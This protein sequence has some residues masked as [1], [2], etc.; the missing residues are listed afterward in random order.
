MN[1]FLINSKNVKN[2]KI[3]LT[4]SD[5][6]FKH[7]FKVHRL[8]L[9]EKTFF[10]D[11]NAKQYEAKLL[12]Y[13]TNI[14]IFEILKIKTNNS[15]NKTKF[16]LYQC[17][18]KSN[19]MDLIIQKAVELGVTE[20]VPVISKNVIIKLDKKTIKHKLKR[21][22]EIILSAVKQSG[23]NIIPKILE[24]VRFEDI[25]IKT[26]KKSDT[27]NLIGFEHGKKPL[28]PILKNTKNIKDINLLVGAE[29]GFEKKEVED[30]TKNSW[31]IFKLKG[32][33]LRVETASTALVS[34]IKYELDLF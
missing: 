11:E 27:L 4:K 9:G 30:A 26:N 20:I 3:F 25:I 12:E 21:W 8:K 34:I 18:P 14:S 17:L 24:P 31:K 7:I 15:I 33:I 5:K 23:S 6:D 19:K 16:V 1:Q 10:L 22:N 32:N 28:K 29:G 13:D 2:K